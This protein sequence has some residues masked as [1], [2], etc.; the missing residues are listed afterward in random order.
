MEVWRRHIHR[1][2]AKPPTFKRTWRRSWRR[3]HIHRCAALLP[4][5]KHAWKR[6]W[7]R[8]TAPPHSHVR[9]KIAYVQACVEALVEAPAW[10]LHISQIR[11]KIAHF[12]ACVGPLLEALVWRLHI[13]Q[14]RSKLP[15]FK[16]SWWRSWR[17]PCGASI[18]TDALQNCS[19]SS[20]RGEARGGSC[21]TRPYSQMRSIIAQ[22]QALVEAPMWFLC[23]F[24]RFLCAFS[25]VF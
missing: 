18:L 21:V 15:T 1:C 19:L 14:M 16:S 12:Q 25:C 5:F 24:L 20:L 10:R 22:F 8:H 6:P 23:V 9:S 2:A 17:R 11:S 7:K 4:V 13:S 3:L